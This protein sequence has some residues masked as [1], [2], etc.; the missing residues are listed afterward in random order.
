MVQFD[1]NKPFEVNDSGRLE[2]CQ[3]RVDCLS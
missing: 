3:I 1:K 2:L